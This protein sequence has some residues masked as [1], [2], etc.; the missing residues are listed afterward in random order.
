MSRARRRQTGGG[1]GL[2]VLQLPARPLVFQEVQ[3]GPSPSPS[4]FTHKA[5]PVVPLRCCQG[6]V[7]AGCQSPSGGQAATSCAQAGKG[8]SEHTLLRGP[9]Y[10]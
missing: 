8:V 10:F 5:G 4:S 2:C 9:L 3:Q 6:T 7:P 1:Q